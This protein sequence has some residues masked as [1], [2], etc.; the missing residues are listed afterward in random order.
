MVVA[1]IIINVPLG[2]T[3]VNK[4]KNKKLANMPV[5]DQVL[6]VRG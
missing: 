1:V 6:V 2:G 5:V 3:F 4:K